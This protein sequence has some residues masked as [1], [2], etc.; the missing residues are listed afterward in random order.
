MTDDHAH[1]SRAAAMLATLSLSQPQLGQWLRVSQTTV[2]RLATSSSETG[3]ISK[4]LD[5]LE[6]AIVTLG[7]K[8]A[9]EWVLEGKISSDTLASGLAAEALYEALKRAADR[10]AAAASRPTH[11]MQSGFG[12]F[13]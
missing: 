11:I 8:A 1:R 6:Q 3:P 5:M 7:P 4:L 9:R 2:H 12:S 13:S 10:D